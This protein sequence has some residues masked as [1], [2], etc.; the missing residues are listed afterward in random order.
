MSGKNDKT[1]R[2]V[3]R[4]ETMEKRDEIIDG[5]VAANQAKIM[6]A[7]M[8]IMKK[9]PFLERLPLAWTLLRGTKAK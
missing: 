7:C 5:Y 4:K 2:R 9:M 1:A 6:A 8:T 3:A